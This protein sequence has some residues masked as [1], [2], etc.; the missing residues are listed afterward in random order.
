M[1]SFVM[2][3]VKYMGTSPQNKR[4]F[5]TTFLHCSTQYAAKDG[6]GGGAMV[7][8]I[9]HGRQGIS[10]ICH[11]AEQTDGKQQEGWERKK[12]GKA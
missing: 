6:G 2:T 7:V 3:L 11:P 1:S 5:R 12:E 9:H 8:N 10:H 4:V